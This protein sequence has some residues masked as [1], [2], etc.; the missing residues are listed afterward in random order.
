MIFYF[1]FH[2]NGFKKKKWIFIEPLPQIPPVYSLMKEQRSI[3]FPIYFVT[4]STF[5]SVL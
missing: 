1:P 4:E 2:S 5:S 3:P